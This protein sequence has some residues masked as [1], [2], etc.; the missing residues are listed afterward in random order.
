MEQIQIELSW[1]PQEL[2]P[3]FRGHWASISRAKK[4]Y[5][6]AACLTTMRALRHAERFDRLGGVRITYE[7]CPPTARA[8]DRD[9]LA[10]RMKA[11]TDGI[12]DALGMNDRGFH[13]APVVLGAKEKGGL[14]RVTI[15][16]LKEGV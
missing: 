10:A 14:V 8:Y 6:I 11:A 3:N 1:P 9:N 5:R 7:F 16:S 13:F 2:S 4:V 15:E 12:S